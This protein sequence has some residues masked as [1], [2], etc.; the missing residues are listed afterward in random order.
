[1]T[2]LKCPQCDAELNG[3]AVDFVGGEARCRNCGEPYRGGREG[4]RR[5]RARL[6]DQLSLPA[7]LEVKTLSEPDGTTTLRIR[8]PWSA[9]HAQ[10]LSQMLAV[11]VVAAVGTICS[12]LELPT[13]LSLGAMALLTAALVGLRYVNST[14]ITVS[15]GVIHLRD[16]PF[17][18]L[19]RKLDA[20]AIEQLYVARRPLAQRRFDY[21]VIALLHDEEAPLVF[22]RSLSDPVVALYLEQCLED[23][24]DIVDRRVTG[25]FGTVERLQTPTAEQA[26]QS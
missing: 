15:R 26:P 18:W 1:M 13:V 8:V 10:A 23:H 19:R 25:E 20:S 7:N 2:Q 24:L 21:N 12:Q 4:K 5:N 22:L 3:K 17:P 14:Y 6:K 9:Q 16:A 11:A